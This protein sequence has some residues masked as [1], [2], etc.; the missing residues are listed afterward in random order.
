MKGPLFAPATDPP[1]K[2]PA[3][4][5]LKGGATPPVPPVR[6][7]SAP[8]KNFAWQNHGAEGRRTIE[9]RAVVVGHKVLSV[10]FL[11]PLRF[12]PVL[13]RSHHALVFLVFLGL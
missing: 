11:T 13:L 8:R 7:L 5:N 3:L 4:P 9:D 10:R 6:S 12:A 1:P 2:L